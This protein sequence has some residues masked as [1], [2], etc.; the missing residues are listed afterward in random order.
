MRMGYFPGCSLTGSSSEFDLS[1]RAV[2]EKIG[3]ELVEVPDWNCCGASSAHCVSHFLAVA[4]PARILALAERA[5]LDE[6]LVP[7]SACYGRLMSAAAELASDAA[8]RERVAEVIEMKPT[9]RVRIRNILETLKDAVD[10][11]GLPALAAP[12]DHKVAC[13]YG[14]LLVRP[15]K[16]VKFDRAEDPQSM[17]ELMRVIGAT[18]VDWAFKV[19]CCG[20]GITI[21]RPDMVGRLCADIL[22]DAVSR[23]A[24]AIVTS[25]PMC[26]TNLD[27]R[28][29]DSEKSAGRKFDIPILY[30]TQAFGLAL[31]MDR[32]RLGL[33]RHLVRVELKDAAAAASVS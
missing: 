14:C 30:I 15:P 13:Y 8:L 29:S 23:G 17:D 18:P 4:L 26:H 7:C 32:K 3:I 22:R 5:G 16:V 20:A 28:R 25:C 11:G 1:L 24:E 6:L 2:A 21:P 10:R 27:M 12:F 9:G 19:E 33:D 31:G